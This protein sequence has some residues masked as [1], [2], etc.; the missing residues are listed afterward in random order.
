[1]NLQLVEQLE[2]SG[3]VYLGEGFLGEELIF[4]NPREVICCHEAERLRESLS[5]VD[6][7]RASG[8]FCAGFL[9]YEAGEILLGMQEGRSRFPYLWFGVYDCQKPVK[10]PA[11]L[12]AER[13]L[14]S[15]ELT[16]SVD[17]G[18]YNE[19][20]SKIQEYIAAGD[21]YQTNYT[22]RLR[23]DFAGS[24]EKLFLSCCHHHPVSYSAFV[25]T[26]NYRI[27]SLSPE[28]FLRVNGETIEALPMKGTVARGKQTAIDNKRRHWLSNSVKNRAE[29][30]MIVDLLRNDLGKLAQTGT[31]EVPEL[32]RVDSYPT[33]HQMVSSV[34]AKLQRGTGFSEIVEATFPSG[35]VTGAPK[36]RTMEII[37]E[38]EPDAR[39]IYTG[40][41]GVVKPD[42]DLTFNVA[43]RTFLQ[44]A[45]HSSLELGVGG[46]IVVDS[47]A[48]LEWEE[49]L[50]KASFLGYRESPA[51]LTIFETMRYEFGVGIKLLDRHLERLAGSAEF[52]NVP[53][54]IKFL[55]KKIEKRLQQLTDSRLVKLLLRED[56]EIQIKTRELPA[57]PEFVRVR[58]AADRVDS[59]ELLLRH[60]SS[61]RR[62]YDRY[63]EQARAEGVFEYIFQ[64]Q[65]DE[66]TEG[67][68]T[69]IFTEIAGQLI[70]PPVE[71]G[72]LPGVMRASF[73]EESDVSVKPIFPRDI[74]NA[75]RVFLTNAVRGVVEVDVI[76]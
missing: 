26:G 21:T 49:A 52:F 65:R 24:P 67:T 54:Q 75:D 71:S 4:S 8:L 30:L 60:K 62:L 44:E 2:K 20:F 70:T 59:G 6:A 46:G 55:K 57:T 9:S 7:A 12:E 37:R 29:N 64:N 17:R 35:S 53:L 69:N 43:I 10:R 19:G 27:G 50:L 1:M 58:L 72:L 16:S 36:Q 76:E 47:E 31:V 32:F 42:G 11:R 51:P 45:E 15:D 56:G 28:L 66:I 25:N 13:G 40:S 73:I 33:V 18:R 74:R 23:G 68:I 14:N 48:E 3:T 34:R 22:L 39:R 61:R 5:R 38:V 63:R 41:I